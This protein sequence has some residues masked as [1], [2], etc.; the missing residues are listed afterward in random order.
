MKKGFTLIELIAVILL[1]G[2]LSV[3]AVAS[4]DRVLKE[5]KEKA[6]NTQIENIKSS[7]EVWIGKHIFEMPSNN[8][9]YIIITLKDLK[10]D[11]LVSDDITNPMTKE[12]FDN[13]L[14]IKITV[15][16]NNYDIEIIE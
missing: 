12:Q 7:T 14:Q 3:I 11:G 1:L 2:V 8:S 15:N 13:S 16:N 4:I 9:E 10:D 6:Y 5:N